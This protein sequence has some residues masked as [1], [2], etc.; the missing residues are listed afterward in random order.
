M[1]VRTPVAH[2]ISALDSLRGFA[3]LLMLLDHLAL[4]VGGLDEVRL[5]LGRIAM[6]LF[7]VLAG[8][9]A[10]DPRW[11][12]LGIAAVGV[13]LPFVVP[14]IDSPNVLVIWALGVV[15]LCAARRFAVPAWLL[16]AVALAAAANGWTSTDGHYDFLAL[17]ALMALGSMVPTSALMFAGSLPAWVATLGRFP[18]RFYVG[19]LLI[20][21]AILLL[22]H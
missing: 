7:F 15:L 17:W 4:A 21:Q 16:V 18:I 5:T 13:G 11:R 12:H 14:W 10:R 9:L 6:P 19:H 3:M 8:H 2:R 22:A 20:L 1:T